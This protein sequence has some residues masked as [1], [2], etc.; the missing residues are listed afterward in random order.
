MRGGKA[1]LLA[2]I[3][4]FPLPLSAWTPSMAGPGDPD[5]GEWN[6]AVSASP[7]LG[8]PRLNASRGGIEVPAGADRMVLTRA[9]LGLGRGMPGDRFG[10]AV[11]TP[12]DYD[13]DGCTDIAV[14][15]PGVAG[16]GV[17]YVLRGSPDGFGR[18][19]T[20]RLPDARLGDQFG[21]SISVGW[22]SS[23]AYYKF[24]VGAPGR[25][26][27]GAS[28]AG[29][30]AWFSSHLS[31]I[32]SSVQVVSQSSRGVAGAAEQRDRFG[33]VVSAPFDQGE[34]G[35]DVMVGV[36]HEDV[37]SAEDAGIVQQLT[38]SDAGS[39]RPA[40]I[41][42]RQRT[43]GPLGVP[44]S[45]DRFGSAVAVHGSAVA[46]GVPG[47]DVGRVRDAGAVNLLQAVRESVTGY[48][49]FRPQRAVTQSSQR[50][51]GTV[52]PGDMFGSTLEEIN[53]YCPLDDQTTDPAVRFAVGTPREDL[54][55][56]ADAGTVTLYDSGIA[57]EFGSTVPACPSH[58]IRQDGLAA[59]HAEAGDRLGSDL[60]TSGDL[61]N[62]L[63]LLIAAPGEDVGAIVDAG[64]VDVVPMRLVAHGSAQQFSAGPSSGL[65]YATL[66]NR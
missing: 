39:G 32:Q 25:D 33:E 1:T 62:E 49:D 8:V 66:P 9:A 26:V 19:E 40:S 65:G 43:G 23:D 36:P 2:M 17:A 53:Y 29:A 14:G 20:L 15:A 5:C 37:G 61:F 55:K 44:E 35:L 22:S 24:V 59:G 56:V 27:S 10:A 18:P 46:I 58:L 42:H 16:T 51:P 64:L 52:E 47:E 13:E 30:I 21:Y 54:G 48:R 50:V 28:D 31:T 63:A 38:L 45:G 12:F 6:V 60:A 34:S 57:F 11:S 7:V 4:A 3:C 41:I